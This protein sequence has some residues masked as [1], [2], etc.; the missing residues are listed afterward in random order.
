MRRH[1]LSQLLV[2]LIAAISSLAIAAFDSQ[3]SSP[4]DPNCKGEEDGCNTQTKTITTADDHSGEWFEL[5]ARE[6]TGCLVVKQS[7][8]R[9]EQ[10]LILGDCGVDVNNTWRYNNGLFHTKLND[11]YCIQV[12]R[13]EQGPEPSRK[14]RLALCDATNDLQQ[15]YHFELSGHIQ[16][17]TNDKLCVEY[18]GKTANVN[19]D[20]I[21]LKKCQSSVDGWDRVP[22]A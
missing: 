12:G 13:G 21:I 11:R 1:Q 2:V 3:A 9:A 16:L 22:V 8:V 6:Q 14:M 5:S 4:L 7:N 10:A 20:D 18:H 15:F 17:K 19:E